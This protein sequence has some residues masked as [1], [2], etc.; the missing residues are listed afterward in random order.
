MLFEAAP[1]FT[2]FNGYISSQKSIGDFP[3]TIA[4]IV[5]VRAINAPFLVLLGLLIGMTAV[6]SISFLRRPSL[7][8]ADRFFSAWLSSGHSQVGGCLFCSY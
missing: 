1:D 8:F 7:N 4:R 3:W 5:S 2:Q 6:E